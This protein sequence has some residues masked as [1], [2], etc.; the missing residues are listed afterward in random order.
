LT[1]YFFSQDHK[2]IGIQFLLSS[3]VL[4]VIGGGL[5]MAIRWHLA[6]PQG[7]FP[8]RW[9]IPKSFLTEAPANATQWTQGWPIKLTD[10]VQID[11]KTIEKDATG[12]VLSVN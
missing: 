12:M 2:R 3:L 9:L 1:K 10:D 6:F 11:G 4:F 5:A 7:D 8:M